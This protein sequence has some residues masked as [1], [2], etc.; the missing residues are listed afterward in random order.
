ML[1]S[2]H[3]RRAVEDVFAHDGVVAVGGGLIQRRTIG[4]RIEG[5]R[6]VADAAGLSQQLAAMALHVIEPIACLLSGRAARPKGGK[7]GEKWQHSAHEGPP[8][9]SKF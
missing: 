9:M 1:E 6:Q 8:D 3:A 2:G 4:S 5:G 7:T